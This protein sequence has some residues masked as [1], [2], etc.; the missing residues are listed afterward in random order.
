[1]TDSADRSVGVKLEGCVQG[2]GMRY[3]ARWKAEEL[4]L[5]GWIQN[6][7]DLTVRMHVEGPS[8]KVDDFLAWIRQGAAPGSQICRCE[9]FTEP[10]EH[11]DHFEVR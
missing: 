5:T 6:E 2:V 11:T 7:E 3:Q 9:A 10:A 8:H 1:M 4:G